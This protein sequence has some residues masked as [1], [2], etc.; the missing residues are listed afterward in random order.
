MYYVMVTVPKFQRSPL[1]APARS[2]RFHRS[3]RRLQKRH[4]WP[5]NHRL[6]WT[7]LHCP[8]SGCL[9]PPRADFRGTARAPGP[10]RPLR[11]RCPRRCRRLR[12]FYGASFPSCAGCC[13][14]PPGWPPHPR[15]LTSDASCGGVWPASSGC[16]SCFCGVFWF[17]R[18]A[19]RCSGPR[20]GSPRPLDLWR[21]GAL[22]SGRTSLWTWSGGSQTSSTQPYLPRCRPSSTLRNACD[23]P[24]YVLR[25][26]TFDGGGKRDAHCSRY[27]QLLSL[28]GAKTSCRLFFCGTVRRQTPGSPRCRWPGAES[29]IL[30]RPGAWDRRPRLR[31]QPPFLVQTW[32][33]HSRPARSMPP[34]PPTTKSLRPRRQSLRTRRM[35]RMM[36]MMMRRMRLMRKK[37]PW[38]RRKRCLWWRC[39]AGTQPRWQAEL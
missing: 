19:R 5:Q 20:R 4:C 14:R 29:E 1:T 28:H 35:M 8:R 27:R 3:A 9:A 7:P 2:P 24:S 21:G 10:P 25:R 34:P 26:P 38:R 18:A 17:W 37:K 31:P 6:W 23:V 11:P 33:S 16:F 22:P 39:S 13:R 12:P 30:L 32:R 15:K 36:M